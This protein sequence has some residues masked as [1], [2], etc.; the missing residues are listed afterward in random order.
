MDKRESVVCTG[1]IAKP[2]LSLPNGAFGLDDGLTRDL[3]EWREVKDAHDDPARHAS[4]G[5]Q[6]R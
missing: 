2:A 3:H 6:G 5:E 1:G 4:D